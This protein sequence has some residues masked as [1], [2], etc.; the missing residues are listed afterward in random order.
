MPLL[1]DAPEILEGYR[2]DESGLRGICAGLVR[3]RDL[4]EVVETV[5]EAIGTGRK[6]LPV[7]C[8]TATTGAAVPQDDVVVDL[9][10]LAGVVDIDLEAGIAEVLP[11]TIT[12]DLKDAVQPSGLYYPPDPTSEKECTLGGNAA[13]NASG[14]RSFRWGM[15][16]RWL[17][18]L[19]VVTGR[20]EVHRFFRRD[21]D[22]NTAGYRP[23]LDPVDLFIGSEGT[24]GIITRLWCRLVPDP[25]PAAGF[26]LFFPTLTDAV[27]LAAAFRMGRAAPSPR[28]CELFDQAALDLVATHPRA[29]AIPSGAGS[30]LYIELD[31][32][33]NAI[34]RVIDRAVLPLAERGLLVDE[35]VVAQSVGEREW[36]RELRH[37]VPERCNREAAAFHGQGG[38]KVST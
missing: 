6:L 11:G 8:Q 2:S 12:R 34:D 27:A 14:A 4:Q 10:G 26:L 1:I 35:T 38:L 19:E 25:G 16:A 9:R 5:R 23:F 33:G 21:V 20:G 17:E 22:K 28:C 13:S 29:P 7:G 15:T 3:V 32:E 18:G 30:A 37:H 31:T 36:L 24:L